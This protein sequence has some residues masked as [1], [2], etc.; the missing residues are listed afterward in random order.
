[1]KR[2][3]LV[4]FIALAACSANKQIQHSSENE[5][6]ISENLDFGRISSSKD[7]YSANAL[8]WDSAWN[9]A[10]INF[11]IFDTSRPDSSGNCPVLVDGEMEIN[12]GR[13]SNSNV[14]SSLVEVINDSVNVHTD[15]TMQ[16]HDKKNEIVKAK[17]SICQPY[18]W[19]ILAFLFLLS[20]VMLLFLRHQTN[21]FQ[22]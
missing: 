12:G 3:I 13:I 14:E 11:R 7:A 8:L 4:G 15:S 1:M 22:K 10:K 17:N 19:G 2:V 18:Q 20:G 6:C 5:L 16:E 9:I 21:N